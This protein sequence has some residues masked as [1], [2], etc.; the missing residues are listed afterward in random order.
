MKRAAN[1]GWGQ[2]ED[3]R[4]KWGHDKFDGSTR[5]GRQSG[6]SGRVPESPSYGDGSRKSYEKQL[7][8]ADRSSKWRDESKYREERDRRDE[9]RSRRYE[10]ESYHREDKDSSRSKDT[11]DE[12]HRHRSHR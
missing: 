9:K 5:N 1:T 8:R 10:S 3:R 6:G 2:K 7:E 12:Y 4:S 11:Y